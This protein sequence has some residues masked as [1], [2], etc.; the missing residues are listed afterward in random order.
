MSK[1]KE[2][3]RI[4]FEYYDEKIVVERNHSDIDADELREM[5][6]SAVKASGFDI[7]LDTIFGSEEL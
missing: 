1:I 7:H 4:T 3:F 6:I 2:P 5:L